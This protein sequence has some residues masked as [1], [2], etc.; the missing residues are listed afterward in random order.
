L[1]PV[2][3]TPYQLQTFVEGLVQ[4]RN[5]WEATLLNASN[6]ALYDLLE[7][8][9]SLYEH[10]QQYTE[11][12]VEFLR[13]FNSSKIPATKGTSLITKIVRYVFGI[14]A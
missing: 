7:A 3:I 10:T 6:A 9:L 1:Y 4:R 12:R 2:A 11:V 13:L 8:C 5:V 14:K